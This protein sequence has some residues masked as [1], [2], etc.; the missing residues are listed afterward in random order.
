MNWTTENSADNHIT[1]ST[2]CTETSE[3]AIQAAVD[4]CSEYAFTFLKENIED[5]SMYCLFDW[6]SS[7][8]RLSV[9]V[10]DDTKQIDATHIVI[11]NFTGFESTSAQE[12]EE[13]V[14]YWVKDLLTTSVA[15]LRFSLV[16]GFS[17]GSRQR[18]ELL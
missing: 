17:R 18:V 3:R 14:K 5:N 12:Q 9:T 10:T 1:H 6:N 2:V 8:A 13:T 4:A 15:F 16:A 11:M 7:K